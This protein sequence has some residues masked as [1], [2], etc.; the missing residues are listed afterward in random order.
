[1][2]VLA[3]ILG[4]LQV[5]ESVR[6]GKVSAS[7]VGLASGFFGGLA[8]EQG[9]IRSVALINFDVEKEAFIATAT[10]TGLIVDIVRMPVYFLTQFDQ[11]SQFLSILVLS[12]SSV[13][14]GTLAGNLVLKRIPE[15]SF[16]RVVS[17]LIL[18]LGIFLLILGL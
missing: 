16:K 13:I 7:V 15:E 14:A 6:L 9:G 12:S 4:V 8:G 18:L 3:G 17:L 5:S 1:M 10:A 2:L 11:V